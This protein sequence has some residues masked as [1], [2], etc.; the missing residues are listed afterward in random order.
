MLLNCVCKMFCYRRVKVE[1]RNVPLSY[2]EFLIQPFGPSG[3]SQLLN[4]DII[5]FPE[6]GNPN[7]SNQIEFPSLTSGGWMVS[8]PKQETLQLRALKLQTSIKG[9]FPLFT[10]TL[11]LRDLAIRPVR[12]G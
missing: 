2:T 7:S 3:L 11:R 12:D 6:E 1:R 4:Y 9:K 5:E 10:L 8:T